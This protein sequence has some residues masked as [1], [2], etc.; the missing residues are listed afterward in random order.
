MLKI[1]QVDHKSKFISQILKPAIK[2]TLNVSLRPSST[3]EMKLQTTI[4]LAT[5]L[6]VAA[7]LPN[8]SPKLFSNPALGCRSWPQNPYMIVVDSAED[9][10]VNS[11]PAQPYDIL[12][13]S[14]I[15]PLLAIDL[16]A[17]KAIA[18]TL[19]TC[20][21]GQP[22]TLSSAQ[23]LSICQDRNN[24]HIL[25]DAPPEKVLVPELYTHTIDGKQQ[26]GL[27]LGVK[28]QTTWGFRYAPATCNE[29]ATVATRDYYEVK[30]L[31]LPES[32]YDTAGY[33]VEFKVFL[34]IAENWW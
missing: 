5:A 9:T 25:I 28:N 7:E 19:Y 34:K 29:N 8:V 24:G 26:D 16:R 3:S 27:Y 11:L 32:E 18:K 14:K 30:L 1:I 31:G 23:K 21:A 10:A 15:L 20:S 22:V 12:F 4:C 17:S 33:E 13:A 2:Y 6:L